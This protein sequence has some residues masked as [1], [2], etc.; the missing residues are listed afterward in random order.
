MVVN[1]GTYAK[2][3]EAARGSIG[4]QVQQQRTLAGIP[5]DR[6]NYGRHSLWYIKSWFDGYFSEETIE[7]QA[8][9]VWILKAISTYS[10]SFETKLCSCSASVHLLNN[11]ARGVSHSMSRNPLEHYSRGYYGLMSSNGNRVVPT[12]DFHCVLEKEMVYI[13]F[14]LGD[15]L[16][17]LLE[18]AWVEKVQPEELCC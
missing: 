13:S 5:D 14:V 6:G 15:R 3:K 1:T 12:I 16:M 17:G 2:L 8:Y 4:G 9:Y 10:I 18:L 7:S 11:C